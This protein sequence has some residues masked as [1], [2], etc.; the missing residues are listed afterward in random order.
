MGSTDAV[1]LVGGMG[2]RLRP[3]TLSAPKPMLPTAGVPFLTH[4]ITRIRAMRWA[5][6]GTPAVGSI[7]LGAERVSGRSRV[8]RPPTRITASVELIHTPRRRSASR[9]PYARDG[10]VTWR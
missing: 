3:L 10:G 1:I 4:V 5:S 6:S 7:G 8:P 2:T 9:V